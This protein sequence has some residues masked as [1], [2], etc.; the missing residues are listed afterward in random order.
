MK[1]N[2]SKILALVL[3]VAMMATLF[4][5]CGS[6]KQ[7]KADPDRAKDYTGGESFA[8]NLQLAYNNAHVA[9]RI[10]VEYSKL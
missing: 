5:G 7:P 4:V 10:A 8:A 6:S 2:L 3:V 1:K 9:S